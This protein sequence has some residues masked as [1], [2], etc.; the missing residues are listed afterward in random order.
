[1][2]HRRPH[3]QQLHQP[4]VFKT[5]YIALDNVLSFCHERKAC[6][7]LWQMNGDL[8]IADYLLRSD[9]QALGPKIVRK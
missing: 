5:E 9:K 7:M 3:N 1:M 2:A 6:G 8:L 4:K